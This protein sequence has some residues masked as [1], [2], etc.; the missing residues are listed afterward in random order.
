LRVKNDIQI[1]K[2]KFFVIKETSRVARHMAEHMRFFEI[3]QKH[4]CKLIM[5]GFFI[6]PNAPHQT[7]QLNI[8]GVLNE[9]ESKVISKRTSSSN[10]AALLSMGKENGTK[11]ILGLDPLVTDGQKQPGL[12][13]ANISELKIVEKIMKVFLRYRSYKKTLDIC[14]EQN[15][16]KKYQVP[17]T[18][19]TIRSL[20]SNSRYMGILNRN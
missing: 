2:L 8:I 6:D 5:P 16:F 15:T 7:I 4:N 12:Y 19:H 11:V 10:L 9:H 3:A 1:D 18:S 14:N 13:C 17:F 20:L